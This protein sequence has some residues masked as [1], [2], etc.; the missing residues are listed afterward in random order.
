MRAP[1][2]GTA[3]KAAPQPAN[4]VTTSILLVLVANL[5]FTITDASSKWLVLA[6]FAAV[7]LAFMRYVTHFIIVVGQEGLA[8]GF[9]RN[10][11]AC[12][13]WGLVALRGV[14][15]AVSTS[16]NFVAL[17][18]L[19]LTIT[20]TIMF[21]APLIVALLSWPILGE[22]V[23]PVR[24]FA[25]FMGFTG[26]VIAVRPFG[27]EIHWAVLLSILAA[28]MLA[29]YSILTRI[30]AGEVKTSTMQF[31]TGVTGVALY[32]PLLLVMGAWS[33][34]GNAFNWALLFSLG[35]FAWGGHQM[36]TIAHKLA[37]ANLLMPFSYSYIIFMTIASMLVFDQNP[38]LFTIAG[39]VIV[40]IASLII[41]RTG[42]A[43]EAVPEARK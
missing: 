26:V 16:V 37:P 10:P 13:R 24:W 38:D 23:G 22:R 8:S 30:L 42:I 21:S 28:I 17:K 25:I 18:F 2:S 4:A 19:P 32:G 9:R 12:E 40:V 7:Q 36:L 43:Q 33:E 41:W 35:V 14:I 1:S 34:P 20:S 31:Y 11:F 29:V 27:E 15:L 39:A 5:G 6:G 3:A